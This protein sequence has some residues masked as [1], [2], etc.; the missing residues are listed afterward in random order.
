MLQTVEQA[1]LLREIM[2][3]ATVTRPAVVAVVIRLQIC[4][5]LGLYNPVAEAGLAHMFKKCLRH[6]PAHHP[7]HL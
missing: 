5:H 6:R 2:M 4:P 1:G 3:V 7:E